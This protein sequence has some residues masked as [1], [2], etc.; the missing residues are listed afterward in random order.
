MIIIKNKYLPWEIIM[1][2]CEYEC[3][4]WPPPLIYK[5][6]FTLFSKLEPFN[7]IKFTII[8]LQCTIFTFIVIYIEKNYCKQPQK[9]SKWEKP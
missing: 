5:L 2:G 9:L 7:I 1:I 4:H 6:N 8:L 3:L